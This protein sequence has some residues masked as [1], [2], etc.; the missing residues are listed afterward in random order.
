MYLKPVIT[1]KSLQRI[2]ASNEYTFEVGK[3]INKY[4][5]KKI[6]EETFGVLVKEVHTKTA[7]FRDRKVGK[8]GLTVSSTDKKQIV[9]K[10]DKK[11]K[12][13]LFEIK[14]QK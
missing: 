10:L 11:D 1:E 14:E 7:K 5:I 8:R 6:I 12:I 4:Q 13:S 3:L 2:E 9:V